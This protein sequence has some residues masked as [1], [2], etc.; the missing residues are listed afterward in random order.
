MPHYARPLRAA[1]I[2]LLMLTLPIVGPAVAQE[3]PRFDV[4]AFCHQIATRNN[5]TKK[6]DGEFSPDQF[7]GC[8]QI[9][10]SAYNELSGN[11]HWDRLPVAMRQSCLKEA[12]AGLY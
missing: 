4:A 6:F 9:E 11:V 7:A 5:E 3:L 1:L 8:K 12:S 10:Q 2:P